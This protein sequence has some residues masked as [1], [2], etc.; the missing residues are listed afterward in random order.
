MYTV[1]GDVHSGNCYKVKLV[2]Q[3]LSQAYNWINIDIMAG[4]TRRA[5]FLSINPAGKIPVLVT[6]DG[7]SLC[8]SNAI[9]WYLAQDSNLIPQEKNAQAHMLQW[10]FFEQYTHEPNIAVARFI[11]HYLGNPD[12][13][14]A[15]LQAKIEKGYKALE[16]MERHLAD[17]AFF[18]AEQYSIADIALFA[19]THIA[20]EGG[21]ALSGFPHILEWLDRVASQD[22]FVAIS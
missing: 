5:G 14:K 6:Q 11:K 2:L 20:H 22:K 10:L 13:K 15:D 9:L 7:F 12:N 21:F 3:Q 16:A 19:Y 4:D 18:V 8:E 1:Y 17:R